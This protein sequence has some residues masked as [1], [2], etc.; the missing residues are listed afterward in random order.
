M[1][2]FVLAH[3]SV[4][5]KGTLH[6]Y[7]GFHLSLG[8]F[9]YNNEGSQIQLLYLYKVSLKTADKKLVITGHPLVIQVLVPSS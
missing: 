4:I 8:N 3:L 5:L 7:N 6:K 2:H 9:M 1:M